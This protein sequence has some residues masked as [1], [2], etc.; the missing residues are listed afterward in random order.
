[1]TIYVF[2]FAVPD[3]STG[4]MNPLP[5]LAILC[6]Y[7]ACTGAGE[8]AR[9]PEDT[10]IYICPAMDNAQVTSDMEQ[11]SEAVPIKPEFEWAFRPKITMRAPRGDAI[12]DWWKGDRPVWTNAILSWFT[13]FE[14][15]DNRAQNSAVQ[16]GSLRLFIYSKRDQR[17]V[18]IDL[19]PSPEVTLWEYPFRHVS[20]Q[21]QGPSDLLAATGKTYKPAYPFFYHGW[22]NAKE[23]DAPDVGAVFAA[24]EF[25]LAV[26]DSAQPDDRS[27][28]K[29][30]LSVGADYY[31]DMTLR[32]SLGFAPGVG[33]G[34]LLLATNSWRT[35]TF[36]V[37]DLTDAALEL[38]AVRS[39]PLCEEGEN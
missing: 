35:A 12:P 6:C 15:Q 3:G 10:P 1:M 24:L 11:P 26:V 30:V 8:P 22:G 13:L 7:M 29:F 21:G 28:A 31:P 4:H 20:G 19:A 25:R 33:N 39:L 34:R 17:W 36:F 16:I 9:R 27:R 37:T 18:R 14:A 38:K 23:I 2:L 5:I 32:W